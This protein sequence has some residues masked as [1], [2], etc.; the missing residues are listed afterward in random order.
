MRAY[1]I[2]LLKQAYM[3]DNIVHLNDLSVFS[4]ELAIVPAT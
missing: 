1:N 3:W 4:Y 2:N